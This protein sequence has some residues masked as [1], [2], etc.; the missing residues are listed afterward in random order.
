VCPRIVPPVPPL[1]MRTRGA[2]M[3]RSR[4]SS[5][6][7]LQPERKRCL[8][9]SVASC[10]A[11]TGG[12]G[13]GKIG[14]GLC[15]QGRKPVGR[16]S[17]SPLRHS[18][19]TEIYEGCHDIRVIKELLGHSAFVSVLRRVWSGSSVTMVP[20]ERVP[21]RLTGRN[22]TVPSSRAS[23]RRGELKFGAGAQT[24]LR[25]LRRRPPCSIGRGPHLQL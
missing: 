11:A 16:G 17:A 15:R 2:V 24:E 5:N 10:S 21:W 9:A 4:D 23:R 7:A 18:F 14:C 22:R 13:L 12:L 19:G 6:R 25:A 1:G 20:N 3:G 8:V